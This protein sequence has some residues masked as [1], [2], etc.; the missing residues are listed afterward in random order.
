MLVD[1]PM[2]PEEFAEGIESLLAFY[3]KLGWDPK[4]QEID[5]TKIIM[6]HEDALEC[7]GQFM[8]SGEEHEKAQYGLV[9][10]NQGP[11]ESEDIPKGKVKL[12]KN[13][14]QESVEAS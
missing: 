2:K 12:L 4:K 3:E 10:M 5:P 11:S 9:W 8:N 14:L 13:W 6:N 1:L 7:M